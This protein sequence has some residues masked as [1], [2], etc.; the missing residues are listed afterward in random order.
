MINVYIYY[1]YK[2]QNIYDDK[3]IYKINNYKI[4]ILQLHLNLQ[5]LR[6]G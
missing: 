6:D 3:L 4:C 1:I 2:E 5:K